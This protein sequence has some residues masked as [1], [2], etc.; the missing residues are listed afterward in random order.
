VQ[1]ACGEADDAQRAYEAVAAEL[2][3]HEEDVARLS[4]ELDAAR[5]AAAGVRTRRDA[6]RSTA[7]TAH[8]TAE[9]QRVALTKAQLKLDRLRGE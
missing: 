9:R 4:A 8:A 5:A 6:A 3:R 7:R 1:Q 2:A